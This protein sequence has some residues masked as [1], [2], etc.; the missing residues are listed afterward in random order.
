M[1]C[2][3]CCVV[4]QGCGWEDDVIA[5]PSPVGEKDANTASDK[6]AAVRFSAAVFFS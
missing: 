6:V 1:K 2:V 5:S 3:Q 4:W